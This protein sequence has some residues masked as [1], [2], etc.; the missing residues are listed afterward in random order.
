MRS[1][2]DSG[3]HQKIVIH[4][5]RV[6][7]CTK[8]WLN[9]GGNFGDIR[10]RD[11]FE[12]KIVWKGVVSARSTVQSQWNEATVIVLPD[13]RQLEVPPKGKRWTLVQLR[14]DYCDQ[15]PC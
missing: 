13:V 15:L 5:I 11:G 4:T 9:Q 14:E 3:N 8:S 6:I 1:R 7:A 10:C 2:G 12:V